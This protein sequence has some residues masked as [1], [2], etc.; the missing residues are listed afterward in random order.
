M[1]VEKKYTKAGRRKHPHRIDFRSLVPYRGYCTREE[2]NAPDDLGA[3]HIYLAL[4]IY[5]LLLGFVFVFVNLV[6]K[7]ILL[8]IDLGL[9]LLCQLAAVGLAIGLHFLIEVRFLF[10]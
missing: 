3:L 9:L 10:L 2:E 8:V 4:P 5:F 6:G 7:M 1:Q